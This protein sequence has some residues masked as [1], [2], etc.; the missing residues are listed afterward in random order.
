MCSG[1]GGVCSVVCLVEKKNGWQCVFVCTVVIVS[2][3]PLP[4]PACLRTRHWCPCHP[5][6]DSTAQ[7][8][9]CSGTEVGVV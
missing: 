1:T 4:C 2:V 6:M 7:E 8:E 3:S 5:Q 9:G